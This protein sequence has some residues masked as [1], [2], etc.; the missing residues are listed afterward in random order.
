MRNPVPTTKS[1]LLAPFLCIL[2]AAGFAAGSS[3]DL[4]AQ[5]ANVTVS[6]DVLAALE[7]RMIGPYRGGRSTAVTGHPTDPNVFFTGTTGGGVWRTDDG[8]KTWSNITDGYLDVSPIGALDVADTDPNVIYVGT[9]SACIRGNVSTG[10]GVYKSTDGGDTW[11]FSGLGHIG[12]VG[13]LK[14]HPTN[15]DVA[16]L[17]AL[18]HAFGPNPERG[19]YR[20]TDG[21]DTWEQVLFVSDSTG[22]VDLA[23]N[24]NNPREIY[25]SAWRGERKPWVIISGAEE[26]GI[27]KTMDGGDT[28]E[29]LSGGLPTGLFGK[30]SVA[31]SPANGNRVWALVEAPEPD[32]GVYRSD[33]RGQSWTRVSADRKLRQRAY[34]YMHLEPDPQDENTIYA[35]NTGL[36]RSIDGGRTFDPITVPHG[37]VHDLWVDPGDPT[38]MIVADDGGGQVSVNHGR[39]W[40]DYYNQPTAEFYS[41]TVDNNFPYRVYGPQQ[42]NS[43]ITVPSRYNEGISPEGLWFSVGGCETGPIAMDSDDPTLIYSGCYGGVIDRWSATTGEVRNMMVYP[44][45]QLG[46]PAEDLLHRFQWV[47]P[48]EVD[49]HDANRIY[50]ASNRLFRTTNAGMS[51]EPISPDLTTNNPAHQHC[52]GQPV[53]C[54]GTGVEVFNTIFSVTV[55]AH[56]RGVIWAGTDD[57]RVHITRDDG[58]T[59]TEIT[60]GGMQIASTV[61]VI[62]VS[63]HD[64]ATAYMAVHRYRMDDFRPYVYKTTDY[65]QSW[66]QLADGTNGIPADYPVRVVREDPDQQGLLYAGTEFGVFVSFDDGQ[67]W[68]PLQQNLPVVPVTDIKVHMTDLVLSTQGRS[69]WILDDITPLHQV[70]EVAADGNGHLFEPRDAYRAAWGGNGRQGQIW[71]ANPENGAT[72]TYYLPEQP[73]GELTMDIMDSS[74]T[75]L[76]SYTS[77]ASEE[78]GTVGGEDRPQ[79]SDE[80][81]LPTSPGSHRFAW[82][83]QTEPLEPPPGAVTSWGFT[84]GVTVPPGTYTVRLATGDWAQ[85]RDFRVLKDPRLESVTVADL[86]EQWRL[87]GEIRDSLATIYGQIE[88]MRRVR[89]QASTTAT[90]LEVEDVPIAGEVRV[91]ADSISVTLTSIE[92][93]VINTNSQSRQDPINFQPM[94]DHQYAYLY[95]FVTEPQGAPTDGAQARLGDLNAEWSVLRARIENVMNTLVAEY[96]A[97]LRGLNVAPII[98]DH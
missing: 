64:P 90:M 83:L 44:Q 55:S 96:N 79:R 69:F 93:E 91:M 72:V 22:F 37:D 95:G 63:P 61:D 32:G 81:T 1:A 34:Y 68:Q 9:G 21:G 25:A 24:P 10:K 78:A 52:G 62:E 41:V 11:S 87:G 76:R 65:G 74:G 13:D 80:P 82:D 42:D 49:P 77:A 47:S 50:H 66:E 59:W 45:M 38:R 75:V 36:Y 30:S 20:T 48:I 14:I 40:T 67:H 8:G 92:S 54:E 33:D 98:S 7:Y 31:V 84:G 94:L 16:Y 17:A 26:A 15:P 6:P 3:G 51:W 5:D 29:K 89:S 18:G 88:R 85:D 2:L 60:P 97:K 53:T 39:T 56:E 28:W 19:V 12:Q 23:M 71:P 4:A 43:T 35:M 58:A 27:W 86:Q 46:S 73:S 70:A 57:G